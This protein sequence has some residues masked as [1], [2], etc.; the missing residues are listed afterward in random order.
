LAQAELRLI[1]FAGK[2][3]VGKTTCASATAIYLAQRAPS[4]RFLVVSVDPAHSLRD[5]LAGEP[6]PANLEV[7]EL[8]ASACLAEFR[9]RHRE[10]LAEIARRGTFL[11]AEDIDRFVDLSLPGLDELFA[12]LRI[13]EWTQASRYRTVI[14]D[15]A[16]SGHTHRLLAVPALLNGWVV[17]LD[18]LLA[19]HRYLTEHFRGEYEPDKTDQLLHELS[20]A[21]AQTQRLLQSVQSCLV[22]VLLAEPLSLA[23]TSRFLAQAEAQQVAIGP[24]LVN[25]LRPASSCLQCHLVHRQQHETLARHAAMLG[26]RELWGIP[27]LP[28]EVRGCAA[29]AALIRQLMPLPV[30]TGSIEPVSGAPAGIL[31]PRVE[32]PGP[33]PP[34]AQ[35]LLLFAGKGGVGK[36]TLAGATALRLAEAGRP[37]ILLSTDPAHSLG[38]CL[39]TPIG[40]ERV[41]LGQKLWALA[42][43][44][45]AE[46]TR[47]HRLYE[48][49]LEAL[50]RER[51]AQAHL[52]FER[53]A[54]D[55]LLDLSP[56]G[57][58]ELV[59]LTRVTELLEETPGATLVIDTAP[60]GHLL[61][62][63]A[64]PEVLDGWLK[65]I[66]AVLL[67][68]RQLVR[69]PRLTDRLIVLSKR[70]KLL[71][72]MLVDPLRTTLYA[73]AIPTWL[74]FEETRDLLAACQ[75]LGI[76]VARVLVNQLTAVRGSACPLC[77][78]L[79]ARE[80]VVLSALTVAAAAIPVT[81]IALQTPPIGLVA[82]AEL[83]RRLYTQ[84]DEG[85][86]SGANR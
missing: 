67:K 76:T 77:T 60:T 41:A 84:D 19:K 6:P 58:D 37:V 28:A 81:A 70:L 3:G 59:S 66:F 8:D 82:I 51:Q 86:V 25:R 16:P 61:R 1:L 55:R 38:D 5:A 85:G 2:G 49:E 43:D 31:P 4:Q 53:Q 13:A 17:A 57:L 74:A 42:P 65:A 45:Q 44:A 22:P 47:W 34:P 21:A 78:A 75:G 46:W 72:A 36:T 79:A 20:A 52:A 33:L 73:V 63:L 64:L 39:G 32:S 62:L 35:R 26:D 15:T 83:G 30:T 56:P 12:F 7:V 18:A 29:L 80:S 54:L 14:V 40:P 71:R 10:T 68:N 11:D 23:E 48:D 50:W 27:L 69:L 24:L 9:G